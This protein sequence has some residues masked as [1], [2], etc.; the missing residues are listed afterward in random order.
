[1]GAVC[2]QPCV[3]N[4]YVDWCGFTVF[5]KPYPL[6]LPHTHTHVDT[7][8]LFHWW[9][10]FIQERRDTVHWSSRPLFWSFLLQFLTHVTAHLVPLKGRTDVYANKVTALHG[11]TQTYNKPH[12]P[13]WLTE[14]SKGHSTQGPS[15][16]DETCLFS[17]HKSM[18]EFKGLFY[19][20]SNLPQPKLDDPTFCPVGS[21]ILPVLV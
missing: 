21:M 12:R 4:V 1:M 2:V 14:Q 20:Q 18:L 6:P 7:H 8:T 9:S 19:F 17:N 13:L 15:L 5:F 16:L 11:N 10:C 3:F